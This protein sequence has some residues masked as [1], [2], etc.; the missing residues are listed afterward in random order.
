MRGRQREG[1]ERERETERGKGEEREG[2]RR[3]DLQLPLVK[4]DPLGPQTVIG[5]VE[6][7]QSLRDRFSHRGRGRGGE[8]GREGR[9]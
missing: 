3:K 7:A 6:K 8:R 1:R 9:G 5:A 2:R 4:R